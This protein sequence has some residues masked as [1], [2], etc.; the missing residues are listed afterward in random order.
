[1]LGDLSDRT[2]KSVLKRSALVLIAVQDANP[3]SGARSK[4]AH[5]FAVML[6][7][8]KA[9]SA[10]VGSA[11]R[12]GK[13]RVL[14]PPAERAP[15][16]PFNLG[17]HAVNAFFIFSGLTLSQALVRSPDLMRYFLAR[18][19]RI[20]PAPY[21]LGRRIRGDPAWQQMPAPTTH[22]LLTGIHVLD[23]LLLTQNA[24]GLKTAFGP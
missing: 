10:S 20:F 4:A 5:M 3:A 7:L 15:R 19:L 1:M 21:V 6:M 12:R 17:Q 18:A 24:T 14:C 2:G 9:T 8:G 22:Q 11:S 23:E 13:C 16:Q